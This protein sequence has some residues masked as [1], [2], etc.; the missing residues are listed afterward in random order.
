[1]TSRSKGKVIT[2]RGEVE[3][4]ALGAVLMHEHLHSACQDFDEGPTRPEWVELLMGYAVPNLKKLHESG[5]HAMV[6]ATPISFR[7]CTCVRKSTRPRATPRKGRSRAHASL[8]GMSVRSRHARLRAARS[9][10]ATR[11]AVTFRRRM[12]SSRASSSS[13][14]SRVQFSPRIRIG[15]STSAARQASSSAVV[16]AGTGRSP[17]AGRM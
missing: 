14:M 16:N 5:C 11:F 3:P 7:A 15:A 12:Y 1:M 2:V 4:E 17:S 13:G 10:P 6:D 9:T 8:L